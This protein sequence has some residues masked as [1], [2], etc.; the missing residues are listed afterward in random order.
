MILLLGLYEPNK[1]PSECTNIIE[2]CNRTAFEILRHVAKM[3][4][5]EFNFF[6]G[7]STACI[8]DIT[9]IIKQKVDTLSIFSMPLGDWAGLLQR[10]ERLKAIIVQRDLPRNL[11]AESTFWIAVSQ[12]P[13]L[14]TVRVKAIPL[15]PRL[16]ISFPQLV[17]LEIRLRPFVEISRVEI[18]EVSNS[19]LAI[20]TFMP[21][22]ESLKIFCHLN[23]ETRRDTDGMRITSLACKNLK[24]LHLVCPIPERLIS[25]IA[26]HCSHLTK[27]YSDEI[28]N[29]DDDDLLQLSLS[30]PSLREICIRNAQSITRGIEYFTALHKLELLE[31]HYTTGQ[32]F[33][34]PVLL[35]FATSCPRLNQILLSDWDT[36]WDRS[37]TPRPFEETA[38]EILFPAAAQTPSYFVPRITRNVDF[39][40]HGL[41]EYAVRIDKVRKDA[42]EFQQL[43]ERLG[44]NMVTLLFCID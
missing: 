27:F 39:H 18:G 23:H 6:P 30:C 5:R 38:V 21:A 29:V 31:L 24:E 15:P 7:E 9:S 1:S 4:I 8:E 22:L 19:I 35:R 28:Y 40:P 10:F 16:N 36:T 14:T 26:T 34:T 33:D 42:F 32:Y 43:A 13:N 20:F 3:K 11:H 44:M 12:M 37:I 2:T 17:N 41:E 25:T